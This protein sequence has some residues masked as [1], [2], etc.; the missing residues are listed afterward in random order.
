MRILPYMTISVAWDVMQQTKPQIN[1]GNIRNDRKITEKLR[2]VPTKLRIY[3]LLTIID[4][5]NEY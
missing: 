3:Q 2:F 1:N 5:E 4:Y